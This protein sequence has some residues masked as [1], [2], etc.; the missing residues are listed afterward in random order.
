MKRQWQDKQTAEKIAA[1]LNGTLFAGM[2][3][4]TALYFLRIWPIGNDITWLLFILHYFVNALFSVEVK[5]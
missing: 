2:L 4:C 1:V 5:P 3:L